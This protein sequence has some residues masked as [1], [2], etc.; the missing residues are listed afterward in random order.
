MKHSGLLTVGSS[1]T[2]LG[3]DR[4]RQAD[5]AIIRA[6]EKHTDNVVR[7]LQL[8][9]AATKDTPVRKVSAVELE[10]DH[11]EL[12]DELR[13]VYRRCAGILMYFSHD[14][15]DVQRTVGV[16]GQ[17]PPARRRSRWSC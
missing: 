9:S 13:N 15:A 17:Q 16:L 7:L 10:G 14:R 2:H 4:V 6:D 1:Y 11:N 3:R 12:S 5:G 8:E